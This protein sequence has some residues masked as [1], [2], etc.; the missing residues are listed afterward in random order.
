[1]SFR[2]LRSSISGNYFPLQPVVTTQAVSSVGSTTATG[3][4]NLVSTRGNT[5]VTELGV[6]YSSS[7][8]VPNIVADSKFASGST[9]VGAFTASMTGLS[10]STLYYVRAYA[11]NADGTAYGDVVTFTTSSA[12]TSVSQFMMFGMGL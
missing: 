6:V 2:P 7:S 5:A 10:A 8:L 11:T 4:G 12:S 3:N 1:M 9:A